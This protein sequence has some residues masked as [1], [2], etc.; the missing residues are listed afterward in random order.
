MQNSPQLTSS[1]TTGAITCPAGNYSPGSSASN[2]TCI[3]ISY[4]ALYNNIFWQ[5]RS[6]QVGVGSAGGGTQNQQ[7]VVTLYNASFTGG[8]GS[9]AASQ[10]STGACPAGSSYWDL[11]VRNDTGPAIHTTYTLNPLNGVLTSTAGYSATNTST[12]PGL[13]HEYCNGSR[14]PPEATC[15]TAAGQPTPCGWQVPPGIAD[16]VVP[17]P[18]FTLAPAATVDE[19][20]NWIN[21][22]WGPLSM[23]NPVS[24]TGTT[25]VFLGNY[26]I[27]SGASADDAIACNTGSNPNT[28]CTETIGSSG[29]TTIVAPQTDFFGN[30]RP[31]TSSPSHI[32]IGAVEPTSG[33]AATAILSVTPTTLNFGN[34][35]DGTTSAAQTLT[36]HNTG[37]AAATGIGLMFTGPFARP[38]GVPGGTCGATLAAGATCTF[39]IVFSPTTLGLVVGGQVAI[40]ASVAVTGSPVSLTGNGVA[41]VV[42]ATL[43]PAPYAFPATTRNCPGTTILQRAACAFDPSQAFTLTNTGNVTLTGITTGS[44]TGANTA[45][46]ALRPLLSSCG[47]VFTTLAPGSTCVIRVQF[48]PQTSESAGP[49][50]VTL[51]VSDAAGTQTS[52]ISGQ[53]N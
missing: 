14:V 22:S 38:A 45:D 47:S 13:V 27:A 53:A 30:T 21:I 18:A 46:F 31:D 35:A 29:V 48:Q 17:N 25:N 51:S 8:L 50:T 36:L 4:P 40:N 19:G 2:G 41:A 7:N 12:A 26:A 28:G 10:A 16:A 3:H 43:T 32:A 9:A 24:S 52:L 49:K 39:N 44:L 20:N 34:Q 33:G 6:F 37:T 42:S 11:G 1:F 23:V 5:N 15:Q